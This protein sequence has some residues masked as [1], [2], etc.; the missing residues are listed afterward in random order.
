MEV[1]TEVAA[2]IETKNL[3][4]RDLELRHSHPYGYYS[5]PLRWDCGEYGH[6]ARESSRAN[7]DCCGESDSSQKVRIKNLLEPNLEESR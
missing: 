2:V 7:A 6:F 3:R 4:V 5:D 1:T